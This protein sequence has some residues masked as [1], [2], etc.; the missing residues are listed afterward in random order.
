MV[1]LIGIEEDHERYPLATST[2]FSVG[3]IFL[4]SVVVDDWEVVGCCCELALMLSSLSFRFAKVS[5]SSIRTLS[6]D[7]IFMNNCNSLWTYLN[8]I[9]SSYGYWDLVSNKNECKIRKY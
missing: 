6:P 5:G 3:L 4:C 9:G 7:F 1:Y 8:T 2:A